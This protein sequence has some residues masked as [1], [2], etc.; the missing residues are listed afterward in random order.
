MPFLTDEKPFSENVASLF[1]TKKLALTFYGYF[2]RET[3]VSLTF[4][5]GFLTLYIYFTLTIKL[6]CRC[7]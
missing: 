2:W 4:C 7:R 1:Y 3:N 5:I 6:L